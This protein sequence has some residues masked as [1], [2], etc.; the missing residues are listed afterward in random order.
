MTQDAQS[1]VFGGH[2]ILIYATK[3]LENP[4]IEK[5]LNLKKTLWIWG[6][7]GII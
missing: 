3:L 6:S 2:A 1:K 7:P 5:K 4:L